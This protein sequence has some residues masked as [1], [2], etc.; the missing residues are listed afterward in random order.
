MLE[1]LRFAEPGNGGEM[2]A[3][4]EQAA[5]VVARLR[6][7]QRKVLRMGLLE[8]MTHSEIA[9]ATGMP[10]G[11]VKTQM[12]RGL[13]QVRQWMNIENPAADGAG[14][15]LKGALRAR[16]QRLRLLPCA[17]GCPG[18]CA[19]ASKRVRTPGS[20]AHCRINSPG[21]DVPV[22]FRRTSR[23]GWYAA[24]ACLVLAVLAAWPRLQPLG[25]EALHGISPLQSESERG[26]LHLID[27]AG[28]RLGRWPLVHESGLP[29]GV[30][31]E[32][33][34]DGETQE[35]YVT[36][37]GLAPNARTAQQYQLWIFDAARDDR[38]PVD[39]GVFDVPPGVE[40]VTVPVRPALFVARPAAFAVTLERAGGVVV[41]DR[42]HLM[43]LARATP[44]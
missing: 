33:L 25:H 12:R 18:A 17:R 43:A 8:G 26:R 1:D 31:G 3:E 9:S 30:A 4:A 34:W 13:I 7:D 36:L 23:A 15:T 5:K 37:T 41:S 24:A 39:G 10:L 11:T 42:T 21:I 35:G 2:R 27:S 40:Q 44:P 16:V 28:S 20:G 29:S 6:P 19:A 38:Y 32:V 14:D 22:S